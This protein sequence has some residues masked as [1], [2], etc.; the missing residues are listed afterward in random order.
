MKG[1]NKVRG[2][3]VRYIPTGGERERGSARD[4][5]PIQYLRHGL[6]DRLDAISHGKLVDDLLCHIVKVNFPAVVSPSFWDLNN[7]LA[8]HVG[9]VVEQVL[10]WK[11]IL[12]GFQLKGFYKIRTNYSEVWGLQE[13]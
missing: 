3:E 6:V 12:C 1:T 11:E 7:T 2:Q 13:L 9:H 8:Q 10:Q 5:C 4:L